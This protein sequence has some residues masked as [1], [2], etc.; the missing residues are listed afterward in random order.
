ME[1]GSVRSPLFFV[2]S[3]LPAVLL[4]MRYS[5][6]PPKIPSSASMLWN[7]LYTSR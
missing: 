4:S 3:I 2:R 6:S 5:R 1:K 7:T